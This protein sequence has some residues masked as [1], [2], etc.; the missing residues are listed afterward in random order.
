MTVGAEVKWQSFMQES[1]LCLIERCGGEMDTF[2]RK[3]YL[4]NEG[5]KSKY[6]HNCLPLWSKFIADVM[7]I[8]RNMS[9][10]SPKKY[11]SPKVNASKSSLK[12]FAGTVVDDNSNGEHPPSDWICKAQGC[13]N[14]ITQSIKV[15]V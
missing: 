3:N 15:H 6:D 14:K 7:S 1:I 11:T 13:S 10:D 9:S 5:L 2:L 4:D 8:A 12:A